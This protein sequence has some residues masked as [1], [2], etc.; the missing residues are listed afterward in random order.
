M[1]NLIREQALPADKATLWA[2]I[3]RPENL[4]KITPDNLGFQIETSLPAEMYNG[5][6]IEYRVKLPILGWQ[7][8]VTEIKHIRDGISFVD[9]MRFGPYAFWYHYHEIEERG[10]QVVMHD[11]VSYKM[12]FGFLGRIVHAIL[13][14]GML[15]EI[16]SFREKEMEQLFGG[17]ST[18]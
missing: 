7:R 8:W 16:F 4:N 12:P 5:L 10:G 1:Y 6:L 18:T 14:R 15:E 11:R 2:F 3:S 9:E 17:K 13:V